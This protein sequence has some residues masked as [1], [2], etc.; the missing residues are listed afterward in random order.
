[1]RQTQQDDEMATLTHTVLDLEHGDL[2]CGGVERLEEHFPT[3]WRSARDGC[4]PPTSAF[5]ISAAV[6]APVPR[7]TQWIPRLT[8][9]P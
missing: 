4:G 8:D 3:E 5:F 9:P 2:F 7:H 1:M 6:E